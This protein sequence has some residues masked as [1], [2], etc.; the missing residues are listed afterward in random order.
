MPCEQRRHRVESAAVSVP[1]LELLFRMFLRF[2]QQQLN[3]NSLRKLAQSAAH[4]RVGSRTLA[5]NVRLEHYL[6]RIAEDAHEIAV[7]PPRPYN[8]EHIARVRMSQTRVQ[9]QNLH[10]HTHALVGLEH[11]TAAAHRLQRVVNH[12]LGLALSNQPRCRVNVLQLF[13]A[14]RQLMTLLAQLSLVVVETGGVGA[15][16]HHRAD[17]VVETLHPHPAPR[18]TLAEPL[19]NYPH[20]RLQRH[21]HPAAI[22]PFGGLTRLG[23]HLAAHHTLGHT[24]PRLAAQPVVVAQSLQ[25]IS[26]TVHHFGAAVAQLQPFGSDILHTAVNLRKTL[27]TPGA[28]HAHIAVSET[29]YL[30]AQQ[31]ALSAVALAPY[32]KSV[33]L[34]RSINLRQHTFQSLV[35]LSPSSADYSKH[36]GIIIHLKIKR[37]RAPYRLTVGTFQQKDKLTRFAGWNIIGS[38]KFVNLAGLKIIVVHVKNGVFS[39]SALSGLKFTKKFSNRTHQP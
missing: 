7:R 9:R 12:I 8:L 28:C 33:S 39:I 14:S 13:Q 15:A 18:H 26:A 34:A 37:H 27:Q 22:A 4:Q 20:Q 24:H 19:R 11:P 25:S 31:K 32:L 16:F 38:L 1:Q 2:Q 36:L 17:G 29:V 30:I 5:L 23:K 35:E 10:Q 6:E 21:R 3:G